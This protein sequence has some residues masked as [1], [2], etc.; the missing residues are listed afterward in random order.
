MPLASLRPADR[1]PKDHDLGA[2]D[3]SISRFG[4]VEPIILDERTGRLVAGHGRVASVRMMEDGGETPPEGVE[5]ID[6]EWCIPVVRGW[7]SKSDRDAEAY[8]LASNR[9]TELGGW[10][11]AELLELLKDLAESGDLDGSGFNG[12]DIDALDKILK[13]LPDFPDEDDPT[14]DEEDEY[15]NAPGGEKAFTCPKCGHE[16]RE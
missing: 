7:S 13:D 9:T 12:D 11:D 10:H 3:S 6:G 14:Q 16:W 5:I 8:L 15:D 4:Y 1:N 2:I